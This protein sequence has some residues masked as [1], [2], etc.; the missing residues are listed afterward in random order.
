MPS[1]FFIRR[2]FLGASQTWCECGID[3]HVKIENLQSSKLEG[4]FC[5]YALCMK[6]DLCMYGL[7][8]KFDIVKSLRIGG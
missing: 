3:A 5:M 4:N 2:V 6:F 8:M 7:C 1:P